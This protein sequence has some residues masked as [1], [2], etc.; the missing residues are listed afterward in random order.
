ML[1]LA[2]CIHMLYCVPHIVGD[3]D[4]NRLNTTWLWQFE[5][6]LSWPPASCLVN[7]VSHITTW[8][9]TVSRRGL[10]YL[11]RFV[12]WRSCMIITY[13][14]H[15]KCEDIILMS[16][17]KLVGGVEL[18]RCII[19][20]SSWDTQARTHPHGRSA[21]SFFAECTSGEERREA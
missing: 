1:A 5:H 10:H 13:L 15:W 18:W 11:L 3:I 4:Y 8:I 19:P 16:S 17:V 6:Y 7:T 2:Q 21:L 12:R 20:H 9:S 14:L